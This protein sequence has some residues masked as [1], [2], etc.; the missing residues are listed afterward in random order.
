M[1]AKQL[2]EDAI[3][4]PP[5]ERLLLVE[6]VLRSLDAPDARLD[7]V[8]LEEA[9]QRLQACRTGQLAMIPFEEVFPEEA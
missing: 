8:W 7:A 4:L 1:T 9:D 3:T 5:E 6:G 2:L